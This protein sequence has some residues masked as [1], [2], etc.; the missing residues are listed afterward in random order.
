MTQKLTSRF[1]PTADLSGRAIAFLRKAAAHVLLRSAREAPIEPRGRRQSTMCSEEI[2]ELI[3][4]AI[5]VPSSDGGQARQVLA[6]NVALEPA[7]AEGTR[8][9]I[10]ALSSDHAAMT[11]FA[12]KQKLL[13]AE[14]RKY[15]RQKCEEI[16]R[17]FE[18]AALRFTP[19]VRGD[20]AYR[21]LGLKTLS[22]QTDQKLRAARAASFERWID[23][24]VVAMEHLSDAA[25]AL[26]RHLDGLFEMLSERVD[27]ALPD[28]LPDSLA[29]MVPPGMVPPGMVPQGPSAR[30]Q[31]LK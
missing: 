14:M 17:K 28:S 31:L 15:F 13:I 18:D 30:E 29:G 26:S 4:V 8:G 5:A 7:D 2:Q 22:T 27:T 23:R 19:H 12:R 24:T 16:G 9:D 10:S 1:C 11:V 25:E 3:S 20:L 6:G 21:L